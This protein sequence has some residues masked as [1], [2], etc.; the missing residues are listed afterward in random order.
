VTYYEWFCPN[1][2]IVDTSYINCKWEQMDENELPK[3]ILWTKPGGNRGRG[4]SKS[5][6]IDGVEEGTRKLGC[7]VMKAKLRE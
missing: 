5:K 4:R 3:K 2:D 7:I 1:S 6:G